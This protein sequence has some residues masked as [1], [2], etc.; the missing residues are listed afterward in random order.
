MVKEAEGFRP[1]LTKWYLEFLF[2]CLLAC[3]FVWLVGFLLFCFLN[4]Y[5][6]V[7]YMHAR[8]DLHVCEGTLTPACCVQG[9]G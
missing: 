3:L 7:L 6:G 2:V 8:S 1:V 9:S 4:L 5:L